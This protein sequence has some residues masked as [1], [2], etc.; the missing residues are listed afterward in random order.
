MLSS[1]STATFSDNNNA[2]M[3]SRPSTSTSSKAQIATAVGIW[4]LI[5]MTVVAFIVVMATGGLETAS[6]AQRNLKRMDAA[7]T[8]MEHNDR[9]LDVGE[10]AERSMY[11]VETL[12]TQSASLLQQLSPEQLAVLRDQVTHTLVSIDQ[13]LHNIHDGQLARLIEASTRLADRVAEA[14]LVALIDAI[15]T[16]TT[17]IESLHEIRIEL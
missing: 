1:S 7:A 2:E 5:T 16:L 14:D 15:R 10:S 11:Q 17:R 4:V 12:L 9:L 13:T 3:H 8:A 6:M